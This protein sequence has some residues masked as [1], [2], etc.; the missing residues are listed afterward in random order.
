MHMLT[1]RQF[2]SV[3][4]AAG[5]AAAT[6]RSAPAA[7]VK[8]PNVIFIL[9]DDLGWGDLRC[10]GSTVS[11]TPNLDRLANE[12]LRFTNFY[13]NS[14]VCSPTRTG[15]MTG[16][17]PSA[18]RVHAHIA[19]PEQNDKRGVA[20]AL[21]PNT[22]TLADCLK[23]AGYA[24]GHFG[25]WHL[26]DVQP[27][28]Y[29]FDE[30]KVY[31]LGGKSDWGED[32]TFWRRSSELIADEAIRFI[33]KHREGPFF[34]NVW[35]HATHAPLDPSDEQMAPFH[36]AMRADR[37]VGKF[38]TP[39]EVYHAALAELD[40]NVGRILDK[41]D[42]LGI[43]D[44]T[45][46]VF[47]S[48][49]GPEDIHI[50][51]V[52]HSGIGS[53][54]PFRGRK[55]SL[56]E[57]GV[58]TPFIVRWPGHTPANAIDETTVLSGVDFLQSIA[59][60]CGAKVPPGAVFDGE[61]MSATLTGTPRDRTK[62]LFWEFRY[63]IVGDAIN[64][65]PMMAVREGRWKLLMNPDRSRVELYDIPND[66]VEVDNVAKEN[67]PV[68]DALSKKL[69]GW[70]KSLPKGPVEPQAGAQTLP[71]PTASQR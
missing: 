12:G 61:D 32:K 2:L 28:E 67:A 56:Y 55:R 46:V 59:T 19:T 38:T 68:V 37:L 14:P 66:P 60:M 70:H 16:R 62:P 54:G 21:D 26:G 69:I 58:R 64:M 48:D 34:V 63:T 6:T 18:L 30:R 3:A 41:V 15:F 35:S 23:E 20:Q 22:V 24:T 5:F 40:R 50:L 11:Q 9:A 4:S 8:P 1:R 39:H 33:E 57:G 25:K 27:S 10:Y 42:A 52:A 47:S 44:N 49:N 43:A 7:T 45:I 17:F 29:G 71:W 31:N 53:P 51:T 13:V 36:D 65:S